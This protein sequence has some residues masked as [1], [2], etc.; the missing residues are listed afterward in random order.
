[1]E[2]KDGKEKEW[3]RMGRAAHHLGDGP[4]QDKW[5]LSPLEPKFKIK[6]GIS[7]L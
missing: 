1:M 2:I 6:L 3:K 7:S 5:W 4:T